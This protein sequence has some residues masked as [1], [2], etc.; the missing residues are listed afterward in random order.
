MSRKAMD[1][2]LFPMTSSNRA[3][4]FRSI[5]L[6]LDQL[7]EF[8]LTAL[9]ESIYICACNWSSYMYTLYLCCVCIFSVWLC[10]RVC[11]HTCMYTHP[12]MLCACVYMHV[13]TT[14]DH[15]CM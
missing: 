8:K 4:Y 3:M 6:S 5:F 12:S 2:M 10:A 13:E 7:I 14:S 9:L 11:A 15:V 1:D